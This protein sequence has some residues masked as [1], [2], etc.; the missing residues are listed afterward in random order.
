MFAYVALYFSS[1]INSFLIRLQ[2]L[3]LACDFICFGAEHLLFM[4]RLAEE[5]FVSK[6]L[7]VLGREQATVQCLVYLHKYTSN[8]T[9][10]CPRFMGVSDND[11]VCAASCV[12]SGLN[13]WFTST[14]SDSMSAHELCPVDL[15]WCH[16]SD[17]YASEKSNSLHA[18]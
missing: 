10:Y 8:C 9:F 7:M 11:V 18:Q 17:Q 3:C 2:D 6:T 12:T 15:W 4:E 5:H 13:R 1:T 14:E 16:F